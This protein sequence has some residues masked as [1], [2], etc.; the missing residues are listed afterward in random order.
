MSTPADDQRTPR[1]IASEDDLLDAAIRSAIGAFLPTLSAE[2]RDRY[3]A[4]SDLLAKQDRIEDDRATDRRGELHEM[5]VEAVI[6]HFTNPARLFRLVVR[7]CEA[8]PADALEI[9]CESWVRS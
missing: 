8:A 5:A 7:H 3:Y 2:Q 6:A 4:I 1:S 9:C